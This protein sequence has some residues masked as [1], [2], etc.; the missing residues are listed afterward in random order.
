MNDN[1]IDA[2]LF[3][4]SLKCLDINKDEK[5][6]KY[7]GDVFK[8]FTY[9]LVKD[10]YLEYEL[11]KGIDPPTYKFKA[12]YRSRLEISKMAILNFVCHI[13]GGADACKPEDWST[14]YADALKEA[15][16]LS[17]EL[18]N[19]TIQQPTQIQRSQMPIQIQRSQMPTQIQRSQMPTQIQRSQRR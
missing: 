5:K 8:Y 13:Y 3:W 15:D 11:L 19:Q 9:E 16:V 4:S 2:D 7:L 1:E 18:D 10:G 12:G 14:Q 6:N 17:D